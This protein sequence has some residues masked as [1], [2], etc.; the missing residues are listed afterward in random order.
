MFDE[1][2]EDYL[3]RCGMRDARCFA[4]RG[5]A[6]VYGCVHSHGLLVQ[7]SGRDTMYNLL[8]Y[9]RG[10]IIPYKEKLYI[11]ARIQV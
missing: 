9:E 6:V 2:K 4:V 10:L 7:R 11:E 1:Q 3:E 8:G 5:Y